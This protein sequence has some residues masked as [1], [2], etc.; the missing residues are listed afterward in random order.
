MYWKP[1]WH[2]LAGDFELV[3]ANAQHIRNMPGRKTEVSDAGW[4]T[5]LLAHG[6]ITGVLFRAHHVISPSRDNNPL[7]SH[8]RH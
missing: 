1:V 7:P 5:D 3:L 2:L 8:P 4:V 6:L